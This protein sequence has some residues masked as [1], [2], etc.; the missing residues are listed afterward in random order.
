[1]GLR[2]HYILNAS[3]AAR[4]RTQ[5]Q[6][7]AGYEYHHLPVPGNFFLNVKELLTTLAE[8]KLLNTNF[9]DERNFFTL[10][11]RDGKRVGQPRPKAVRTESKNIPP[12]LAAS[13]RHA[14]PQRTVHNRLLILLKSYC[15]QFCNSTGCTVLLF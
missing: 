14:G 3:A 1:M 15:V 6:L 12:G 10:R 7:P 5:E 4:Y 9:T 13:V 11:E 2:L 8:E